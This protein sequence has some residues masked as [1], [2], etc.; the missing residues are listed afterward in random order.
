MTVLVQD[1]DFLELA[2]GKLQP[3][4]AFM[5]GKIKIKG[6]M[7][8]AGKLEGVLKLAASAKAKL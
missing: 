7:G 4:R 1:K 8:L 3:Q 5:S 6:N 2:A